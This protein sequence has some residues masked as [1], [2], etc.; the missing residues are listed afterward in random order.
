MLNTESGQLDIHSALLEQLVRKDHPYRKILSIVDFSRLCIPLHDCYCKDNGTYGYPVES[1][2][3]CLL[4]QQWEDLS[5]RQMERYLQENVSAK[6]FCGFG[7]A[8]STPGFVFF[9]RLRTRIGYEKLANMFNDVTNQLKK[10]KLVSN[11]FTFV[12]ATGIIS[13]VSLWNE[14]DKAIEDA[15][16]SQKEIKEQDGIDK[17]EEPKLT[18]ENISKYAADKDARIGCKGKKKF[19]FGYKRHQAVDMTSG[20]IIKVK[21]TPANLPDH[22]AI[23]DI[24]PEIGMVLADKGYDTNATNELLQERNLHSGIIKKNNRKNKDRDKDRWLTGMRMPYEGLFSKADKRTLYRGLD[25]VS[26][27]QTLDALCQNLK[28]LI[29]VIEN[30]VWKHLRLA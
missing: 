6:L 21:T 27:H 17:K 28:R 16:K 26:F 24:L 12:D 29:R 13:K 8:G 9:S 19:W 1:A 2:F 18:N 23:G 11:V 15:I 7:L 3:K 5:D 25:R 10:Q 14:R 22:K 30:P 20:I 4:L